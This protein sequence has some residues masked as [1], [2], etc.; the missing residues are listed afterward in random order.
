MDLGRIVVYVPTFRIYL[1][2]RYYKPQYSADVFNKVT[3][4]DF[5]LPS[6]AIQE[7]L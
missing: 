6:D 3:V 2:G 4:T 5:L 7:K 1:T